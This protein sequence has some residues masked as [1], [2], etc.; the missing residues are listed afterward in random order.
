MKNALTNLAIAGSLMLS[1]C[2]KTQPSAE[3][4]K[5]SWEVRLMAAEVINMNK[6]N[7]LIGNPHT[8]G[9]HHMLEVTS[10]NGEYRWLKMYTGNLSDNEND[11][12]KTWIDD[13][14]DGML[15]KI[16]IIE[17]WHESIHKP[18]SKDQNWLLQYMRNTIDWRNLNRKTERLDSRKKYFI[19]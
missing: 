10:E 9:E 11:F 1:G 7:Q 8:D 3:M 15:D 12:F 17:N 19:K 18:S 13:N 4:L 16:L 5:M 6:S 14:G 2:W